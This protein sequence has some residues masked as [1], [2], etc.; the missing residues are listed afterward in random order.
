MAGRWHIQGVK[1][2]VPILYKHGR[3]LVEIKQVVEGTGNQ[4]ADDL[5]LYAITSTAFESASMSLIEVTSYFGLTV[6]TKGLAV[7]AAVSEVDVSPVVVEGGEIEM[8]EGFT[9]VGSELSADGEV[10]A[11]VN[12]QI[13]KA[14]K[15]FGCLKVPIFL[16]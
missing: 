13:A 4:F 14:S 3:K 10:T 12:C 5:A 2:G 8:V 6:K 11:E 16:N 9:Y 1:A 7:G 15:A